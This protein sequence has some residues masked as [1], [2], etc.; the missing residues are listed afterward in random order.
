[1]AWGTIHWR[2]EILGKNTTMQVLL[3]QVGKPPFPTLYL[4][5]GLSDDSTTWM[6]NT[7]IEC[8]V[9]SLPLVVIMPDGYR[10]FYTD[11]EQGPA[12]G[13]HLGEEM[14]ALVERYFPLDP[15][16]ESRAI[17]GLSMGGYGA[18]R[19]GL[20]YADRF[21][22]VHSHSGAV[23]YGGSESEPDYRGFLGK[24]GWPEERIREMVH[25]FGEKPQGT[26]HDIMHLAQQAHRRGQLPALSL[27][28]GVDDF[29]IEE[30]RAFARA[31][32]KAGIP[33]QYQEYPGAHDWGYWDRHIQDALSFHARNLG[34]V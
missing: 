4:L 9:Q 1:M 15:R 28:C 18:L 33:H 14:M 7:R 8:Y 30:N 32:E 5:H 23:L 29:L 26:N 10:G 31:L 34:L 17:S 12:Y 27:D 20:K 6:R 13:R 21:C 22:S 24:R 16:R 3:P 11:H 19:I 2:S 25:I